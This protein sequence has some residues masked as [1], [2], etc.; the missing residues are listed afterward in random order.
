MRA[1]FVIAGLV[2]ATVVVGWWAFGRTAASGGNN[3]APEPGA[4]AATPTHDVSRPALAVAD[5]APPGPTTVYQ[6]VHGVVEPHEIQ[7]PVVPQPV[8]GAAPLAP[9]WFHRDTTPVPTTEIGGR[10]MP[11]A[12]RDSIAAKKAE[13]TKQEVVP[14]ANR[15]R[16]HVE[17]RQC[18][19]PSAKA[20]FQQLTGKARDDMKARCAKH[21]VSFDTP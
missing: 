18:T 2:A 14:G 11:Q 20:Q 8:K 1:R 10:Q 19:D 13:K 5:R 6:A 17:Q 9:Y 4:Q 16:E 15:M 21:G 3:A 12:V 7:A